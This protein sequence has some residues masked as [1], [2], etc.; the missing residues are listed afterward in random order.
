[1][2]LDEHERTWL[3]ERSAELI[4]A[5]GFEG[6]VTAP[7]VLPDSRSFPEPWTADA[8]SVR[9]VA[10]RLLGY[11]GLELGVEL[12][13]FA[14]E[15]RTEFDAHGVEQVV[16]H[17]GAAAWFA[18][19]DAGVCLFGCEADQ[20]DDPT[21][22]VAAMAHEVAHAFRRHHGLEVDDHDLEERLTDLTTIYLGFGVLTTNAALRHRSAAFDVGTMVGHTWS[23][24]QLGY[25][26][27]AAMAHALALWHFV[28]G[29]DAA[30]RKA[31]M[32]V[33]EP[34]QAAWFK[35]ALASLRDDAG[36]GALLDGLPARASWPA[37]WQVEDIEL[38]PEDADESL[39][40]APGSVAP[41]D[42]EP[43]GVVFRVRGRRTWGPGN[44]GLAAAASGLL[45][46][47][48]TRDMSGALGVLVSGGILAFVFE[49]RGHC[50][51]PV[52]NT[53]IARGADR[54]PGCRCRVVGEIDHR[55][56]RLDAEERWLAGRAATERDDD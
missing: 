14:G 5:A 30:D 19:I 1:V 15:R 24:K 42:D 22:V 33:L 48:A 18:G 44:L 35:R 53:R 4:A 43:D 10:M 49:P 16:G 17:E 37:V 40:E 8:R 29:D 20:L 7:L 23:R 46:A 47:A 54:C 41:R 34:N 11:A 32:R 55:R 52:C 28:R 2:S 25:L 6:Y 50:S 27:P 31:I 3:L 13:V 38:P 26:P 9:R 39:D 36:A 51:D 12:E 45:L 56:E 21:G